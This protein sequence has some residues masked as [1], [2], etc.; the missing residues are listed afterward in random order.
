MQTAFRQRLALISSATPARPC[1]QE[2]G[3]GWEWEALGE[4]TNA[5]WREGGG[6][7]R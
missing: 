3:L 7:R 4:R 1:A 5:A 2:V 6:P